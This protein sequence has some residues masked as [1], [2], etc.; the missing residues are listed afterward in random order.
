MNGARTSASSWQCHG[1]TASCFPLC[2]HRRHLLSEESATPARSE[3][4]SSPLGGSSCWT[5][6]T[7][8]THSH[9]VLK[10]ASPLSVIS[11]NKQRK[12]HHHLCDILLRLITVLTSLSWY[13][14]ADFTAAVTPTFESIINRTDLTKLWISRNKWFDR[15]ISIFMVH[16]LSQENKIKFSLY[17]NKVT[18]AVQPRLNSVCLLWE[19]FIADRFRMSV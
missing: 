19:S 7:K 12:V 17:D 10:E 1:S 11:R 9:S 18:A 4:G 6:A 3:R 2:T 5:P 14:V 15:L 16:K 13:S 8:T